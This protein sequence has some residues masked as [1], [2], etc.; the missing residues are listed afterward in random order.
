MKTR[1]D[2]LRK[3]M[4]EKGVEAFLVIRP[5]NRYYLSGFTGTSGALLVTAEQ[6]R[7]FTDFRYVEQ[8]R[9]QC[10]YCEII[11]INL[12]LFESLPEHLVQ[13]DISVLGC[14]GDFLTFQ[15]FSALKEKLNNI[16][17]KPMAGVV[18][19]LREIKDDQE[20]ERISSSVSLA[21]RAFEHIVPFVKPGAV[22]C[23]IAL[24]LEFFMRRH[25]ASRTAFETI[26]A[27]GPRSAMPHGV[28]S[29][30]KLQAG[31]FVVMDFG[32]VLKG[33]HSDITRTV[34]VGE[35]DQK[36][37]QIY[38]IVLEAQLAALASV[39]AGTAAAEVDN[40][41]R[42]I[43]ASS[44]YGENFGH[45]TGHGVG[46]VIHENPRVSAKS[47]AILEKGM[48]VTVEPGI[49]IPEWGG[50]RIEDMVLVEDG[51]CRIFT[52]SPKSGLIVCG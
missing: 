21:D 29:D 38:N 22:E 48:V 26:V 10:P 5:E 30:R 27:S 37:L 11:Y 9:Q 14:E 6:I 50:V 33:Y 20:I 17:L 35:P 25:G 32:A 49:Y 3:G 40:A 4:A 2:R 51:G 28:A 18:E 39:R 8:A 52:G 16:K 42:D 19:K 7:F 13:Q 1:I 47:D 15:E 31:D 44:G 12:P 45:G 46:L 36:Q 24:E 41:A 43:I 23:E 34:V